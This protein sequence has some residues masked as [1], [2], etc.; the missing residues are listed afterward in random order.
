MENVTLCIVNDMS[1]PCIHLI[2]AIS[3]VLCV[4]IICGTYLCSQKMKLSS[5]SEASKSAREHEDKRLVYEK[6]LLEKQKEVKDLELKRRIKEFHQIT[7]PTKLVQIVE[8]DSMSANEL[9]QKI[10]ILKTTIREI[11]KDN[12]HE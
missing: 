6:S 7:L 9:Q 8:K 1:C 5:E 12:D 3:M 10:E 11:T 2:W 4:L